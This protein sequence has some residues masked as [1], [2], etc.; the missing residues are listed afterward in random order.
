MSP[1]PRL[2]GSMSPHV[3]YSGVP[4]RA[5]VEVRHSSSP[6]SGSCPVMK[7][8]ASVNSSQP[9]MPLMTMPFA[10]MGPALWVKAS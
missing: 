6:V 10:T 8:P 4:G 5:S 9:L 2:S 3:A 7:Q 1:P